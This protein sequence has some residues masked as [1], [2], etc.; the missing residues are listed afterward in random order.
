MKDKDQ[1]Q[2]HV[3]KKV[4]QEEKILHVVDMV[5][6]MASSAQHLTK[7]AKDAFVTS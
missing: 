1:K 2:V 7:N 6:S 5:T 4:Q 3:R